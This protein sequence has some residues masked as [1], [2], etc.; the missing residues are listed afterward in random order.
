[1]LFKQRYISLKNRN[2]LYFYKLIKKSEIETKTVIPF[3]I[4]LKS[5]MFSVINMTKD[6]QHLYTG[7]IVFRGHLSL[8]FFNPVEF[9]WIIYFESHSHNFSICYGNTLLY[10]QNGICYHLLCKNYLNLHFS[11]FLGL[12]TSQGSTGKRYAFKITHLLFAGFCSLIAVGQRL[13]STV[14]GMTTGFIRTS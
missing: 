8:V 13:P 12:Q 2:Q 1:M 3:I 11:S 6:M 9:R 5:M 14:Y 7:I 4:A 10:Y